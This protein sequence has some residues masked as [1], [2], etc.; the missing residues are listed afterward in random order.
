[1]DGFNRI[2]GIVVGLF[3]ILLFV[4]FLFGRFNKDKTTPTVADKSGGIIGGIFR[5][6][7][8]TPTKVT[9]TVVVI[10]TTATN[11]G[12]T[13][14]RTQDR[15]PITSTTQIPDTGAELFFPLAVSTL[16]AGLF[17]RRKI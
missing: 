8:P 15:G 9:P 7:T 13:S 5:K 4:G 17:I 16:S 6:K 11:Q 14:T 2:L 10:S 1:M 12:V 3:I